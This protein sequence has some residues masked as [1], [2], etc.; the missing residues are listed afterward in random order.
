MT[1]WLEFYFIFIFDS[2]MTAWEQLAKLIKKIT[3]NR[4]FLRWDRRSS[5]VGLSIR[6]GKSFS[7]IK[8]NINFKG[9]VFKQQGKINI[10][11]VDS[12]LV[13][14]CKTISAKYI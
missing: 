4:P 7:L 12:S 13:R 8:G 14:V 1:T 5:S 10:G 11:S 2:L 9:G 3:C 6:A